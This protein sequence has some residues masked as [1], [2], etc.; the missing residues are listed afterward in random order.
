MDLS[1]LKVNNKYLQFGA[2]FA[3][4]VVAFL[5][6]LEWQKKSKQYDLQNTKTALDIEKT[7][8]EISQ[9]KSKQQNGY[10]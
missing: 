2:A 7:N 5:A 1:K 8:L 9:L 3:S 10:T 6:F 4:I